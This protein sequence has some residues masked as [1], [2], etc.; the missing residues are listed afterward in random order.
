MQRKIIF[1]LFFF[2]CFPFLIAEA[3]DISKMT[4]EE[5]AYQVMM[6]NVPSGNQVSEYIKK[7][8][9]DGVP[10][11]ILLFK[12]N[13][14]LTPEDTK[15]YTAILLDSLKA[16][17]DYNGLN[18]IPPLIAVDNE[19]GRVFRTSLLTTILPSAR[20][21]ASKMTI[22]EVEEASYFLAMQ[23]KLLGINFNLA[24]ILEIANEGN[25]SV[26]KDRTFSTSTDVIVDF[27]NAFIRGMN[28]AGVLCSMKHFPG[29]GNI[30]PHGDASIISC[31]KEEF[32]NNYLLPFR[33]VIEE[34]HKGLA[35]LLSHVEFSNID[36]KPFCISKVGI[37]D[38]V[39][40]KLKFSSLV[41]TDDIAMRALKMRAPSA[42]NAILALE[43][44]ADMIMCSERHVAKIIAKIVDKA[45]KDA[46]F[47]KR[48]NEACYNVLKTKEAIFD[49]DSSQVFNTE[50]FHVLKKQGDAV[51]EKYLR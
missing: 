50:L 5:K 34:R 22:K 21:M 46:K 15:K 28:K 20:D 14:A 12:Q 29:N 40:K 24:P 43:A 39:R 49:V 11:A 6:L 26:L 45:K 30:D 27:S 7:E 42:D 16:T 8:F 2:L 33:K 41:L 9:S 36:D 31:S 35:M 3:F 19:G 23:M 25:E 44:G 17:S 1:F 48:L 32:E 47:L 13:L 38:V 4:L 18:F 10:G 51:V 37:G